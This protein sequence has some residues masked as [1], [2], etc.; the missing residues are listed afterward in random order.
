MQEINYPAY[1]VL[2]SVYCKEKPNFLAQSLDS[3][4]N[5]SVAPEEV[6]IVEDGPL[7]EGLYSVLNKYSEMYP[8]SFKRVVNQTNMGLGKALNRGLAVCKNE[9]I[10]RMDT[11]DISKPER[12]EKQLQMFLE[13]PD[14]D[15]VGTNIAEFI[16]NS[17]VVCSV[18]EVPSAHEEICEF[19]KKRC[20]FNHMTVMFKKASVISAD[21]YLDWHFNEDYYLWVRMFLNGSRFA[22]IN[23]NLVSVRVGKDMFARRGG[24]KYYKS[25]KNLFKYMYKHKLIS[26]FAYQKAKFIRFVVQV[27]MTNRTRQWFFKKFARN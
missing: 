7:T 5:Q 20:P 4:F 2:L 26:W 14:L 18:R 19:L 8:D 3:M 9:L 16:D 10:A 11:D 15:V 6:V 1:S 13:N 25:E 12:C 22:N 21:G 24:Y 17:Q 27:L 23:E